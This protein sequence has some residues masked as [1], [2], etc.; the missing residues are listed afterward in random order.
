MERF[1]THR[2]GE[3]RAEHCG[4]S[5]VLAGWLARVRELGGILFLVLR[6]DDGEVQLVIDPNDRED[7]VERLDRARIESTVRVE[8]EVR[9]RPEGTE[10]PRLATGEVEVVVSSFEVLGE[11][12]QLPFTVSGKN[13]ASE[14]AR[15]QHRYLDLR[16]ERP[17]RNIR[18]RSEIINYIRQAMIARGFIEVHTPILTVSSPEGARD[19]LVPARLHPGKF[20]ALPQAPQQFKQLLMAS[21]FE[22]YFQIA[23]CFR[24]EAGRLDR[25]PGEFYQLDL[26]MAFVTQ[27]EIFET[28]EGLMLE[29]FR[30]FSEWRIIEPFPRI[31]WREAMNRWG[32]DK[33]DLRFGMELQDVSEVLHEHGPEFLQRALEP[34]GTSARALVLPEGAALSR[35]VF[36]QY[37]KELE[38]EGG[39]GLSWLGW[40][41]DG[42]WRGSWA[43][44]LAS[45]PALEQHLR[46]LPGAEPGCAFL[47]IVEK[48]LLAMKL[49]GRLRARLGKEF[50][51]I[52]EEVFSFCWIVD[53]PMYEE[54]EETGQIVFSHNPFSM[55]RGGLEALESMDPLEILANQYDLVCNGYELSSGAIR[56]HRPDI[57]ARAFEIA[58][59]PPEA[60][61]EK[62][63]ALHGAFQ[64]GPP[65][66]GGIAPGIERI[67][68]LLLGEE[69]LREVVPFPM[70]SRAQD[71]MMGAPGTVSQEQLDELNLRLIEPKS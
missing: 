61:E 38:G 10:N 23:P 4:E 57:M 62:F 71:V 59:Y 30:R 16:R 26:E 48:D 8:G 12:K 14:H 11:A 47:F 50:G 44:H 24:D 51:M 66:H 27:D 36:E 7:L 70:N 65:P 18:M 19:F 53:F 21:G 43:K 39:S 68:M 41:E 58:G 45:A 69:N 60:L 25:S 55:P 29:L 63:G 56:N 64:Y 52:E 31:P 5:V 3:L 42:S 9:L 22:R 35:K 1:R 17:H 49:A 67:L 40:S 6:G 32:S 34:Q 15:L 33:P 46:Q 2:C 20:Y 28:V 54:D 37:G 13:N